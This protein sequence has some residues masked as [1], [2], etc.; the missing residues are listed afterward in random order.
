MRC[1]DSKKITVR[2]SVNRFSKALRRSPALR[3]K[4]PSN[5]NRSVGRP[6]TASADNTADA[7]GITLTSM[8]RSTAARTKMKPGSLTV[9]MPASLT[10][11]T[12]A[13][14]AR[15]RICSMRSASLCSCRLK[16]LAVS[17]TPN[18]WA[19]LCVERVSSAAIYSAE[20]SASISRCDASERLPIGVAASISTLYSRKL[21]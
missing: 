19:N 6:L 2:V 5:A 10:T 3:G 15:S 17:L 7:P 9:G 21:R 16:S 8:P 12:S 11:N 4:N 14:S 1:G 18:P 20:P 13:V